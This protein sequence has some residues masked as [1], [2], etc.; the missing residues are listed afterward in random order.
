MYTPTQAMA[1]LANIASAHNVRVRLMD[2]DIERTVLAAVGGL[3][4]L[5]RFQDHYKFNVEDPRALLACATVP[6][7]WK[8][9]ISVQVTDVFHFDRPTWTLCA[10]LAHEMGHILGRFQ[11]MDMSVQGIDSGMASELGAWEWAFDNLPE[12]DNE[13]QHLMRA[14]MRTHA[15]DKTSLTSEALSVYNR[16]LGDNQ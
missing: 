1:H 3:S 9:E 2:P 5:R 6:N 4:G 11:E 12:W 16:L 13:C 10:I 14:A 8:K 15:E 7:Y